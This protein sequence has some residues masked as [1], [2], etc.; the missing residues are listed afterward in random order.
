MSNSSMYLGLGLIFLGVIVALIIKSK[1][2]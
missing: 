2:E 1:L